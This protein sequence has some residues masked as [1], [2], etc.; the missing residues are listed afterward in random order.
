MIL[1]W[2]DYRDAFN[3]MSAYPVLN[4]VFHKKKV[5]WAFEDVS[6]IFTLTNV[7]CKYLS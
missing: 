7:D 6:R 4:D 3:V 1:G 5:L 2:A